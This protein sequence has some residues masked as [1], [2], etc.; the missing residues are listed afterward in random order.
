MRITKKL[1]KEFLIKKELEQLI[2]KGMD[3]GIIR[4]VLQHIKDEI[5]KELNKR[6]ELREKN[7][8]VLKFIKDTCKADLSIM[9]IEDNYIEDNLCIITWDD[10]KIYVIID[11]GIIKNVSIIKKQQQKH[12]KS[13]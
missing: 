2:K 7:A 8:E 3:N 4:N 6:G 1:T 12:Y 10:F 5:T 11:N 9:Q 13:K